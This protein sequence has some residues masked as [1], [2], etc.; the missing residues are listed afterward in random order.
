M[1]IKVL[2]GPIGE[3]NVSSRFLLKG[4]I[5]YLS[6]LESVCLGLILNIID[7]I[8]LA[9]QRKAHETEYNISMQ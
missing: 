5:L 1:H 6:G 3:S 9:I 4:H 2:I 8:L 7:T